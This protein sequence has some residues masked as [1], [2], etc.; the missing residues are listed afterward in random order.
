MSSDTTARVNRTGSPCPPWCT[1]D[2]GRELCPGVY[3]DSHSSAYAAGSVPFGPRAWVTASGHVPAPGELVPAPRVGVGA[4]EA[5]IFTALEDAEDLAVLLEELGELQP[6]D[7]RALAG[8][9]RAA[10]ATARETA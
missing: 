10:A 7:L 1:R 9:V 8:A 4:A 5:I 2:H 6:E 3:A